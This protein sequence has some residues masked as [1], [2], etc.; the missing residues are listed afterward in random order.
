[1][2]IW[3]LNRAPDETQANRVETGSA[4]KEFLL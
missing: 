3:F 2:E 1:M 4:F